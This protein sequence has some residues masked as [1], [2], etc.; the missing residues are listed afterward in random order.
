M[1]LRPFLFYFVNTLQTPLYLPYDV[2]LCPELVL[3]NPTRLIL[4]LVQVV[5]NVEGKVVGK[6][7]CS[8][9]K[10]L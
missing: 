3:S 10:T 8:F 7:F 1:L 6:A 2:W 4:V 5:G 9:Y